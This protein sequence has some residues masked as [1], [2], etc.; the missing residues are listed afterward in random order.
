[1]ED[2][3]SVSISMFDLLGKEVFSKTHT[4]SGT[5]S[6]LI[7]INPINKLSAGVYFVTVKNPDND[8]VLYKQKLIIR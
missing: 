1:M 5:G 8:A 2:N 3:S 7:S 6:N 4:T